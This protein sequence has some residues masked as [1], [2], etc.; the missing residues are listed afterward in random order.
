MHHGAHQMLCLHSKLVHVEIT[1]KVV[2]HL[3]AIARLWRVA[4]FTL[5]DFLHLSVEQ[6]QTSGVPSVPADSSSTQH[7]AQK[8]AGSVR[9]HSQR[10][11]A[12]GGPFVKAA[13]S[14]S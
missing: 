13:S 11:P 12:S 3:Q 4:F 9:R 6:T 7:R 10:R 5:T 14:W 2:D 1:W 8:R